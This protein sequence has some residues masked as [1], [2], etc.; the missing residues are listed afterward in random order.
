M[1][2]INHIDRFVSCLA[3][4]PARQPRS[5]EYNWFCLVSFL[6][7]RPGRLHS[8][9]DLVSTFRPSPVAA[10]LCS[11]HRRQHDFCL[12]VLRYHLPWVTLD[13]WHLDKRDQQTLGA[14]VA[15][16][17]DRP[18]CRPLPFYPQ[19]LSATLSAG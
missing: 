12:C 1:Q 3:S 19:N 4:A 8:I 5:L 16:A 14:L 7:L 2:R 17:L 11:A 13:P 10:I 18:D 9:L 6:C 15:R